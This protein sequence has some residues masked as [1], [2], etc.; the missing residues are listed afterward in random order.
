MRFATIEAFFSSAVHVRCATCDMRDSLLQ[1][2]WPFRTSLAAQPRC[3]A[4]LARN[5]FE[6]SEPAILSLGHR[7]AAGRTDIAQGGLANVAESRR[8]AQ[9]SIQ[10]A[11]QVY[12]SLASTAE[13]DIC[14]VDWKTS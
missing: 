7:G 6:P 3:A 1:S 4:P 13:F 8:S 10:S 14:V 5:Y 2:T 11:I 9:V 12:C